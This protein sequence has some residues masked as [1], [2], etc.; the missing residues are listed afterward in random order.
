MAATLEQARELLSAHGTLQP[1]PPTDWRGNVVLPPF[2]AQFYHVVGPL[3]LE[4]PSQGNPF[5]L[6]RLAGLWEL[7]AGYRWN[8][9]T[10]DPLP[11]W[12]D[13]WLVVADQ[14]GDPFILSRARGAVSFA[15]H[16]AG[17]WNLAPLFPDLA[18]MAACLGHLGGVVTQAGADLARAREDLAGLLG[19]EPQAQAVLAALDWA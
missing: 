18:T 12:D 14:G 7:Q 19:S 8:A 11:N 16:G 17:A 10:S 9:L 2:V 13:D 6:P 3:D 4:I 5:F 1:Q 15:Q